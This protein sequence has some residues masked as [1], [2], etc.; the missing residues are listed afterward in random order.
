MFSCFPGRFEQER[1]LLFHSISLPDEKQHMVACG[2]SIVS[3]SALGSR[4]M[5]A[6]QATMATAAAAAASHPTCSLT[7][8]VDRKNQTHVHQ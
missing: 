2:C 5:Q 1:V 8:V 3:L 7:G 6:M 4:T